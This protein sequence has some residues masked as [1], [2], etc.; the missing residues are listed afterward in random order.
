MLPRTLRFG[1]HA[2]FAL[3]A[4]SSR[5]R[6]LRSSALRGQCAVRFGLA[7][8]ILFHDL[9]ASVVEREARRSNDLDD[10]LPLP[11]PRELEHAVMT[12]RIVPGFA[13][14]HVRGP[15]ATRAAL[16][17]VVASPA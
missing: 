14:E 9:E 15:R 8:N 1:A 7:R 11:A 10:S 2:G 12:E 3:R 13:E 5:P 4:L 16:V 17:R 6:T